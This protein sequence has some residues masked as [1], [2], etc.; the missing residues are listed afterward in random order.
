MFLPSANSPLSVEGPSAIISPFLTFS[1]LTTIGL[2]LEQVPWLERL[3]LIN[4]YES[5]PVFVF[6]SIWSAV[7]LST[8]P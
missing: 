6:T 8:T 5:I 3:N 1:P 7:T 4:L 2:W